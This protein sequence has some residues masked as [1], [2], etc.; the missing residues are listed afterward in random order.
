VIIETRRAGDQAEYQLHH[1]AIREDV[2]S[3]LGPATL[4][5]HHAALARQLA[6]WPPPAEANARRYALRH[7]LTHRAAAGD[8]AE[9]WRFVSDMN[10]LEAKCRELGVHEAEADVARM[11]ERCRAGGHEAI[12]RRFD[13]LARALARESQWLRDAPAVT[14]GLVWNRLRRTA[15]KTDERP[16]VPVEVAFL[17]VRHGTP[18]ERGVPLRGLAGHAGWVNACAVTRDGRRTVSASDDQTLKVWDV[19][20]GQLLTTLAGHALHVTSCAVAPDGRRVVSA[21]LDE[22]LKVWDLDRGQLLATFEGHASAVTACAVTPDGRRVVSASWDLTLSVWDLD[23]SERLHT[24]DMV[25]EDHA[26]E[27][28]VT[29]DSRRVVSA[30]ENGMLKLLHLDDGSLLTTFRGHTGAVTACAVTPDGQRVVS[31]SRDQTLKVWD[32]ASGLALAT[33]TG[34]TGAV[35]ACAVT[36]DG[37]Q[38]VSASQDQTL[39]VWDLDTYACLFTHHG[40]APYTAVATTAATVVAGDDC[41][42]VWFLDCP[43]SIHPVAPPSRSSPQRRH[44]V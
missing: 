13:D 18:R 14:A 21:S 8:W 37:R 1:D 39:K 23:S 38:V 34:H 36:P 3:R 30:S 25:F 12:G 41:G 24:F 6:T 16:Q 2:A 42:T 29:P 43:L 40:D 17:R 10:F 44:P 28:T 33:F 32:L 22:T 27:L 11:A 19:D 26:C 15:G 7:A 35:T 9:A 31:A 4:R 20:S 5:G